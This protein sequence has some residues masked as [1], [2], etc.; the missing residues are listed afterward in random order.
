MRFRFADVKELITDLV[1]DLINKLRSEASPEANH[2]SCSDDELVKASKW[3]VD[4]ETQVATLPSLKQLFR[5][6]AS[7]TARLQSCGTANE[8]G[9]DA[10]R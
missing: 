4:L 10:R 5:S 3:K 7:W 6:P 1:T 9:R 2:K 8:D